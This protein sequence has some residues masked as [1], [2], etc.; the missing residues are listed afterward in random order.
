MLGK[1]PIQQRDLFTP[2]LVDFIDRKHEL[3]L[4]SDKI[5]WSY[6]EKEFSPLYSK[7]GTK[8]MP[9][10]LMVGC[11]MLKRLYNLGDET[12]AKAWVTNT[13]MQYFTGVD[14]FQNKFTFDQI[15]YF[16]V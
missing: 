7:R 2:L 5:D 16:H 6:F 15:I 4:L 13:Y 1:S 10:R 11:L 8:S 14:K 12:V 9:I 3:A